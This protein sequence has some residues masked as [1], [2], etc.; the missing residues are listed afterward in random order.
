MA[1]HEQLRRT[2]AYS[3][4]GGRRAASVPVRATVGDM[5]GLRRGEMASRRGF[6]PLLA[7]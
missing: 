5:H 3:C 7:P 1:L 2:V 4:R 6:E